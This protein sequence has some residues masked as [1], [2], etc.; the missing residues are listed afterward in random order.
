MVGGEA[1]LS[2]GWRSAIRTLGMALACGL[3]CSGAGAKE[4]DRIDV[5][6][7]TGG[8]YDDDAGSFSHCSVISAYESDIW[9]YFQLY[10]NGDFVVGL[11]KEGWSLGDGATYNVE[12]S[13]DG[14]YR[15]SARGDAY[16]EGIFVDLDR[17]AEFYRAVQKGRRLTVTAAQDDFAFD[18]TGT[19]AALNQLAA[20]SLSY[21]GYSPI[22]DPFAQ[23]PKGDGGGAEQPGA[24]KPGT[25][26][27]A[28]K[29]GGH[30]K[31]VF[32]PDE[33][34]DLLEQAEFPRPILIE[35][36]ELPLFEDQTPFMAWVSEDEDIPIIGYLLFVKHTD[37]PRAALKD[38]V[39]LILEGCPYRTAANYDALLERGGQQVAA[40][41]VLCESDEQVEVSY[42]A[43]VSRK[44]GVFI[45]AHSG[46]RETTALIRDING[47][48]RDALLGYSF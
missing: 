4:L 42:F 36:S 8:A 27:A 21:T 2:M 40:A 13:V 11:R 15:R 17:D 31:G 38:L 6:G 35:E 7:W 29:P 28:T 12:V 41:S 1:G 18:L 23:Q 37:Q 5:A 48:L 45:F 3:L 19:N 26:K 30:T 32:D 43:A 24:E 34:T 46:V 33:V 9:L 14:G 39:D 22:G 10:A 20:C 44:Q 47:K 16:G 25:E